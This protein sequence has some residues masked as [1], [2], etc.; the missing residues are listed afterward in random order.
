MRVQYADHL[1][2]GLHRVG[3][4]YTANWRGMAC[5][6]A[7][8]RMSSV[9]PSTQHGVLRTPPPVT[10]SRALRCAHA[11]RLPVVAPFR[12]LT[13]NSRHLMQRAPLD[14]M[15][16]LKANS[17]CSHC[18]HCSKKR[19]VRIRTIQYCCS[20]KI[21]RKLDVTN[22]VCLLQTANDA[23]SF[24]DRRLECGLLRHLPPDAPIQGAAS[25]EVPKQK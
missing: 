4:A 15:A 21:R 10:L 11:A 22:R 5:D 17:T 23:N 6:A 13:A 1:E 16:V 8:C 20:V 24:L 9:H 14:P 3:G 7:P 19:L 18:S 12:A 25:M 2:I